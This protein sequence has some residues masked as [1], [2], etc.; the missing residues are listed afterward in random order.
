MIKKRN[1]IIVSLSIFIL[2]FILVLYFYPKIKNK[3][4]ST[5]KRIRLIEL[6]LESYGNHIINDLENYQNTRNLNK[7]ISEVK[8]NI[9][10]DWKELDI[11]WDKS[12]FERTKAIEVWKGNLVV[13]LSGNKSEMLVYI[14]MIKK[15]GLN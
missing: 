3:Y 1:F 6:K 11:P 12:K 15:N 13:G 14:C 5:I 8:D 10:F 4:Y 7:L 2:L 9:I